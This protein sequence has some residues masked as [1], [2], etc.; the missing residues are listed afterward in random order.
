MRAQ[1]VAKA[2]V[3]KCSQATH[4]I[5][6]ETRSIPDEVIFWRLPEVKAVTGLSKSS[7][8]ALVRAKTF[9][10]PVQLGPRTVGWVRTEVTQWAAERVLTARVKPQ[11]SAR[12]FMP[13]PV[14]G[15]PWTPSRKMA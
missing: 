5:G 12:K 13:R 9:P 11:P 15:V 4:A 7:L 8:Y 10:A 2:E 1:F 6:K 3:G 14:R